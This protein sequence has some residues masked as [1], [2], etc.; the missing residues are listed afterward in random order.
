[1]DKPKIEFFKMNHKKKISFISPCFNE[2]DNVNDLYGRVKAIWDENPQ[3]DYEFVI[4]DNASTDSTVKRLKEIASKDPRVKIIVNT[5]NFGHIR[6]PYWES[7]RPLAMRL[8]IWHLIFK[9][10]Q[11]WLC[12]L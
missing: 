3:F 1:M 5:R 11:N 12:S 7:Y 6:S 10:P 9:I 8:S 2:E 4:I